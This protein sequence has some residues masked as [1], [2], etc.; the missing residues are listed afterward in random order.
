MRILAI[1]DV[2]GRTKWEAL[3]KEEADKIVFVGDY[4]DSFDITQVEQIVNFEKIIEWKRREPNKVEL[5]MGNHDYHYLLYGRVQYSGYKP[6]P[7]I[8]QLVNEA[9]KSD[10]IKLIW[11]SDNYLFSHAGL[12]NKF[13]TYLNEDGFELDDL[14]DILKN[15]PKLLGFGRYGF[16]ISKYGNDP[17]QGPLW[18]RPES[19]RESPY[20]N[21]IQIV[22]HSIQQNIQIEDNLTLIDV[23]DTNEVLE[24]KD[25]LRSVYNLKA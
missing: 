8:S 23:P 2:H 7:L 13:M 1:G 15:K 9:V 12:S 21:W 5:L 11:I 6:N 10:L 16:P 17:E 3:Q 20:G 22:G 19:L 24:I 14:N 4:F 25:G 18:I